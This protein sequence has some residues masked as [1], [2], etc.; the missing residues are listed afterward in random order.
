MN[1][2]FF[3]Y[4][5][6]DKRNGTIGVTSNLA[7]RTREHCEGTLKASLRGMV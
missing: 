6:T 3:I 5:M 2:R 7:P 1:D 4:V